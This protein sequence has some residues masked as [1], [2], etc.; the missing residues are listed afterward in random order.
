M[1]RP[2]KLSAIAEKQAAAIIS[3]IKHSYV[4][5]SCKRL[6]HQVSYGWVCGYHHHQHHYHSQRH[7]RLNVVVKKYLF[8]FSFFFIINFILLHF[9]FVNVRQCVYVGVFNE[10]SYKGNIRNSFINSF[11]PFNT[12]TLLLLFFFFFLLFLFLFLLLSDTI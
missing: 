7:N 2:S 1:D 5:I 9:Y 8:F 10:I 12:I 3:R 4:C 6:G 11:L